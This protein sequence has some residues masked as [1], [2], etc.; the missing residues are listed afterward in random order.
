MKNRKF[1]SKGTV[2]IVQFLMQHKNNQKLLK[3][4]IRY[5]SGK[6]SSLAYFDFLRYSYCGRTCRKYE[7]KLEKL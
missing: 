3:M 2:G 1:S 7:E 6:F 4:Q 5:L